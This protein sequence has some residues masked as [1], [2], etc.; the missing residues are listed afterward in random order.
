MDDAGDLLAQS[1]VDARVHDA[2]LNTG[3]RF[4]P[5][6]PLRLLSSSVALR[7]SFPLMSH[8]QTWI[9]F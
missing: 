3:L 9:F 5:I 8:V 2:H 1:I 7:L 6:H 4:E